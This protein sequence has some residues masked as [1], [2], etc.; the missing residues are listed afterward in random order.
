MLFILR[1]RK[2]RSER[3]FEICNIFVDIVAKRSFG[4]VSKLS[5]LDILYSF[6]FYNSL[7]KYL[8]HDYAIEEK[9]TRLS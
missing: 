4:L 8:W 5:M 7:K 9:K 6:V 2:K 3:N 1:K